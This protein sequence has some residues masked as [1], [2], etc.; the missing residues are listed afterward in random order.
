MSQTPSNAMLKF[1]QD[2]Q[3]IVI[4]DLIN[5]GHDWYFSCRKKI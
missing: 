2:N 4:W 1:A 5:S 3:K